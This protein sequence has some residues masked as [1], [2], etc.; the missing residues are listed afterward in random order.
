MASLSHVSSSRTNWIP[1]LIIGFGGIL[2]FSAFGEWVVL[3]ESRLDWF[4]STDFIG[5]LATTSPFV[6]GIMYGGY[7]LERS[8]LSPERYVRIIKWLLGG[9][10]VYLGINLFIISVFPAE[11]G[12]QFLFGWVRFAIA[13][14]AAGGLLIGIIEARALQR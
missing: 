9:L 14:G 5:Y 13:M 6:L 2:L 12:L 3:G 10:V 4:L 8:G 1:K 7:W 11:I